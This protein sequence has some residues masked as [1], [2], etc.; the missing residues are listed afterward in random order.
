[1]VVRA[2]PVSIYTYLQGS[3]PLTYPR[4]LDAVISGEMAQAYITIKTEKQLEE[5]LTGL[6]RTRTRK[7]C[8][9][10]REDSPINWY[11]A[12]LSIDGFPSIFPCSQGTL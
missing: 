10:P 7:A 9:L 5:N 12:P 1:M 3:P 11:A 6:F 8:P 4:D 2:H